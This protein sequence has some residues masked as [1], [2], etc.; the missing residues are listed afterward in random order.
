MKS[1]ASE[2]FFVKDM[3]ITD[4]ESLAM[5]LHWKGRIKDANGIR[6]AD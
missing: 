4:L 3:Y 2:H 5:L 1:W 6:V